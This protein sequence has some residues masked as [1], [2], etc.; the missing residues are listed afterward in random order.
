M[1]FVTFQR[2]SAS[3]RAGLLLRGNRVLDISRAYSKLVNDPKNVRRD[4]T[5]GLIEALQG[6]SASILEILKG[7]QQTIAQCLRLETMAMDGNLEDCLFSLGETPLVAPIPSP[8]LILHF[9]SHEGH[10][11]ALNS[12]I[13]GGEGKLPAVWYEFP[14]YYYGNPFSVYGPNAAISFPEGEAEMD[15][16]LELAAVLGQDVTDVNPKDAEQAILGYTIVNDWAARGIQ[17]RVS[18]LG[19]GPSL[20][21]NFATSMGPHLVTRDELGDPYSLKMAI[22]LNGKVVSQGK[23]DEARYSFGEMISC[24]SEGST[25]PAGT[26][27]CSGAFANG[28]GAE[29]GQYLKAGDTV[30]MEIQGLGTLRNTVSEKRR[31]R[32]YPRRQ[33]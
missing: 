1:R 8:P 14:N 28:S 30:E 20:A 26:L 19:L 11:K 24:A 16:E 17:R 5:G 33:A 27:I 31:P 23:A 15:F 13:H 29:V 9:E 3:L 10:L 32:V 2:R 18:E 22:K 7:G 12:K 21:K 4:D 25:L 6:L